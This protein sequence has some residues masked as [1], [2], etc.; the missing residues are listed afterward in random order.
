MIA[1]RASC[2]VPSPS[3]EIIII[4]QLFTCNNLDLW[5]FSDP[6]G[7][8]NYLLCDNAADNAGITV[9]AVAFRARLH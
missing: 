6:I 1:R 4:I 9:L 7:R 5:L 2:A 3:A 8:T